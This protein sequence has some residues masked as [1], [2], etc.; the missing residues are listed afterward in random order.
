MNYD[1][2]NISRINRAVGQLQ[3]ISRMMDEERECVDIV[4]QLTAVRSSID[5]LIG[6]I[7]A[8]NLKDCLLAADDNEDLREEKIA[9]A[10]K[11]I[12]KK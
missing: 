9:Q 8:D 10:I 2:K 12:I 7:V 6:K 5:S 11:M 3:G 1:K 4:T